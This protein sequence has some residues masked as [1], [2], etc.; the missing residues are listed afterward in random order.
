MSNAKV[1]FKINQS[2]LKKIKIAVISAQFNSEYT[3][4]ML[5][6]CEAILKQ[7]KIKYQIFRVPGSFEIP[8]QIKNIHNKFDGFVAIGCLIKGETMHFEYIASSVSQALMQ[9]SINLKKPIGFGISTCLTK[10]QAQTRLNLGA[11]A[12]QTVLQLLS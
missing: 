6:T 1:R 12:A 3:E 2:K 4:G 5:V 7:Y 8:Y 10:K 9:L 11:Q